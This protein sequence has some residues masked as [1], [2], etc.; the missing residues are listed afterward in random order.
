MQGISFFHI[1]MTYCRDCKLVI[2]ICKE[3]ESN[4]QDKCKAPPIPLQTLLPQYF[5]S[6]KHN[7]PTC[8]VSCD[9]T[10]S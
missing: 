4:K 8:H 1:A 3:V 10:K 2:W 6:S 7:A 5:Y 9:K